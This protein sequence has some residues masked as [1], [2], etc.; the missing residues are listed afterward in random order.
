MW[1]KRFLPHAAIL[2]MLVVAVSCVN[3]EW[4][5]NKYDF[6]VKWEPGYEG[7]LVWGN[8]SIEDMLTKFDTSGYLIEDSTNFLYFIFDTSETVYADDYLDISDQDFLQVFFQTPVDIPAD[9]LGNTGDTIYRE[10]NESFEWVKIGDERLDSIHMKGGEIVIYVTSTIKHTGTLRI[11]SDQIELNGER[12]EHTVEISDPTGNF[13]TTVRIPLAGAS[14]NLDNSNPDTTFLGM[15]FELK[16]IHSGADILASEIVS[17]TNT[18]Q[19]LDFQAIYGYAGVHD[20]L[21]IDKEV[22]EF[23]SM[24]E[25]FRGRIQLADPQLHLKVGNSFGVPF[26]IELLDLEARFKDASMIPITLDPGINPIIID[27]PDLDQRGQTIISLAAIDSNNSNINEIA[28]TD[29]TGL[30]FSVNALGNPTGFTNNFILDT[31]HLDVNVEVVIPMHLRAEGLELADSFNF[32]IG[33]EEDLSR[34]NIKSFTFHLATENA[35]PL[36]ASI[37]VYLMDDN[38]E[39][40]DSL[41]NEQNR[42]ILP[43]GVVDDDGKVIMASHKEVD[44]PLSDSQIDNVFIT[45]WV[46]FKIFMETTDQG[47]RDIKFYSSNYLGFELGAKAEVSFTSDDN[48]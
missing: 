39:R 33:G 44:V 14:L 18:F 42:N 13:S 48:N 7:P 12:Y 20:S 6:T 23:S 36:D 3:D 21:I 17:I 10:K 40:I 25:D 37:Q 5:A 28:S 8:L 15:V 24:P 43:S 41:F 16:L 47:T 46:M 1:L 26:G 30:Q 19:D 2:Y 45:E 9:S 4:M 35:L 34:E 22:I 29:L 38:D 27:A 11:Y 32:N 31:S